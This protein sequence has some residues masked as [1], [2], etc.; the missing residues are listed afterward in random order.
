[1]IA[2]V[3]R[4]SEAELRRSN[5]FEFDDLLACPARLLAEHPVRLAWLRQ[6]WR[7]LLVDEF[8]DT[9]PAQAALIDL[10]AGPGGNLCV[11]R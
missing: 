3:W 6:R 9:S 8:Q 1:V 11:R 10:L 7:W 5:A 4:E 2:A